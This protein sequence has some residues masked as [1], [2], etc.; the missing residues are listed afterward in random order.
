[1]VVNGLAS[2]FPLRMHT[3]AIENLFC[4]KFIQIVSSVRLLSTRNL[5]ILLDTCLWG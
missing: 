4:D 5:S 2:L 1:M 3:Y